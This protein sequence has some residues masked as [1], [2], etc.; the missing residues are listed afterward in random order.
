MNITYSPEM[1][2][3][4]ELSEDNITYFQE[5]IWLLR[6]ATEIGRVDIL[7]EVLLLSSTKL[8]HVRVTLS[9]SYI[10]FHF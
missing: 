3:S 1:D 6:W 9:R 8:I 4:E 7:F 5:L 2:I 10:S